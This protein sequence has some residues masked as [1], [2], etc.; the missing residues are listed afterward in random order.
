M[1]PN[2]NACPADYPYYQE[3][4]L[5]ELNG[6]EVY[7]T[8]FFDGGDDDSDNIEYW[9]GSWRLAPLGSLQAG[10]CWAMDEPQTLSFEVDGVDSGGN[11]I[12]T[13][14]SV[15]FQSATGT[16][17]KLATSQDSL[18]L[19]VKSGQSASASVQV[20]VPAGQQWTLSVFPANQRTS[21]LTVSPMSGSGPATVTVKASG[22]G[23][24]NGEYAA[25]LVFQSVNTMPQFVDVPVT[26]ANGLSSTTLIGG[27][28]NGAS[29]QQ[30]AAPGMIMSV[31]GKN[32]T[33]SAPQSATSLPLPLILD[34][35][36]ATVNGVPAPFYYAS[37][38]Q[39]NIQVPYET[40][41]GTAILNVNNNGQAA[42]YSFD[43]SDSAPGIFVGTG[44][45]VVPAAS[46]RRGDTLVM[47]ITGEGDSYPFLATGVSPPLGTPVDQ[48]PSPILPYSLTI[49]GVPA[50]LDFIGIP[51]YLVGVTQINFT[52]PQ[53]APLGSQPVV[54]TVGDSTSVAAMLTVSK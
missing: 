30:V 46:G 20:T 18:D 49:G 5:Q 12:T 45:V 22:A 13:T 16:P 9:F 39:L 52:I 1:N 38:G 37:Q 44:S 23:L 33:S 19:S 29:F 50:T 21:W 41:V 47:F 54:V 34:G 7:L 53:N 17:G 35:V 27:V 2:T 36:T 8:N 26:L 48:L 43:V 4:N 31:F 42:A 40:P 11:T 3:L 25:M 28:T 51:Y 6:Y 14:L 32:F 15:P 10:T 24:A